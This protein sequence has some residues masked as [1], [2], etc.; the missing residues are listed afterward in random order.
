M[1]IVSTANLTTDAA[2]IVAEIGGGSAPQVDIMIGVGLVKDSEAVFFQY[3]GDD[4]TQALVR[5]NGKPVTRIGPVR[6]TGLTIAEDVYK[7]SGFDGTKLN[8]FAETQ[9][10]RTVMITSGLTTI[11]SQCLITGLM[12]L[13]DAQQLD[14]LVA[15]DSWKGDSKMRPC[16][17][18]VR[19]NGNKV[20][21]DE[22]YALLKDARANK[23]D[24][25]KQKIMRDSIA[26]VNESL[27]GV[28]TIVQDIT[29][30]AE[31]EEF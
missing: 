13:A 15:I 27:T 25:A 22:T 23:D 11:W 5:G 1:T 7:D 16:F 30:P 29:V 24:A 2:S 31:T 12:G 17:A 3:L 10:G 26:I 20:T 8:L 14:C 4:S 9:S 18:C 19:N 6:I 21:S 28:P